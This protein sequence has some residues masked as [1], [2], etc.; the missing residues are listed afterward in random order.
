MVLG[1][2]EK[3]VGIGYDLA[4]R[5]VLLASYADAALM[6]EFFQRPILETGQRGPKKRRL[7]GIEDA[8][9]AD[10]PGDQGNEPVGD[11]IR[12][13]DQGVVQP[14]GAAELKNAVRQFARVRRT[15]SA[16]FRSTLEAGMSLKR[17]LTL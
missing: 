5:R 17:H 7:A 10:M 6:A 3:H 14:P 13:I 16:V 12:R 1:H 8:G 2:G 15:D 4:R 11:I 9:H